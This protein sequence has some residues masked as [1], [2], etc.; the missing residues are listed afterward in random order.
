MF[1]NDVFEEGIAGEEQGEAA[2]HSSGK[3][4]FEIEYYPKNLQEYLND[5]EDQFL[6]YR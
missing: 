4:R 6:L 1:Q 5:G 3:H 2:L